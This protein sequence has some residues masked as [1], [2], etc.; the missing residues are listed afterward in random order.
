MSSRVLAVVEGHTEFSVLN[1]TVA[2]YLGAMGV[3]FYPKIVGRPGH[4]GG[5]HRPFESVAEE[6]LNLFKQEP[7]AV[8]TTFFDFYA[9]P[10]D[11]PG[12][13]D[14]KKAKEQDC[15]TAAVADLVERAWAAEIAERTGALNNPTFVP[16]VQIH[17]LEALIYAGPKEMAEAFLDPQLEPLFAETVREC[18]GCE[19]INDR[20]ELAPSKRIE[21][22]FSGYRKGRDKNKR[23]DRRP[24]APIIAQQIGI[25]RIRAACPHF[26]SWLAK[27]ETF[28]VPPR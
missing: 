18:G 16:Y 2:S 3:Y 10:E 9:M 28:A 14:A 27:L 15:P 12:V 19:E 24:H 11:W 26:S 13:R 8:V 23:Q 4:K 5:V 22:L 17:E 21:S 1:S 20:P 6:I 25:P 7:R